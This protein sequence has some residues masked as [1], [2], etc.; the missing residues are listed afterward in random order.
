ML[1]R[2]A[3]AAVLSPLS[4]ESVKGRSLRKNVGKRKV[5][6][7]YTKEGK[8]KQFIT[9]VSLTQGKKCLIKFSDI[10]SVL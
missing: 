4:A 3:D 9:R 2:T 5:I 8:V 10:C 7:Q 6:V 1:R